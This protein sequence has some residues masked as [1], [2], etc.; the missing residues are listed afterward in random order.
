[1][2]ISC[3]GSYV[4]GKAILMCHS[5]FGM[6]VSYALRLP[7]RVLATVVDS[8]VVDLLVIVTLI[9]GVCNCSIYLY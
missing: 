9:V 6:I 8:I 2:E 7:L 5:S 4:S 3:H 1:M